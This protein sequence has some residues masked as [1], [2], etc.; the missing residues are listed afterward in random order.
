M[1]CQPAEAYTFYFFMG[2]LPGGVT[3]EQ[4]ERMWWGQISWRIC[5]D[6]LEVF[7]MWAKCSDSSYTLTSF[8]ITYAAEAI[9]PDSN[10]RYT[11][12]I[13]DY[14]CEFLSRLYLEIARQGPISGLIGD[15]REQLDQTE[16]PYLHLFSKQIQNI[17]ANL[18]RL[19]QIAN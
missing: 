8:L 10:E 18:K 4:L 16:T 6:T 2:M 19:N 13:C 17:K 3:A 5:A 11:A 14:Y 12:V 9:D 15:A 7:N 1:A